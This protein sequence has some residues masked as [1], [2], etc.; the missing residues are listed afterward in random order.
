MEGA[1][2]L[3]ES[4]FGKINKWGKM[5]YTIYPGYWAQE[6]SILEHD[7][8]HQRTYRYGA[9]AAIPFGYG[10]SL[11]EFRISFEGAIP[12]AC[13][14][15]GSRSDI[16]V[17]INVMNMGRM[18]GDEVTFAVRVRVG[19]GLGTVTLTSIL[20]NQPLTLILTC[21]FRW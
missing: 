15:T 8:T 5:P 6:N 20:G 17:E 4:I 7:V 2:A 21:T 19:L 16:H 10:L 18:Q 13:V 12:V 3:A 14:H 11:T 9:H 1:R